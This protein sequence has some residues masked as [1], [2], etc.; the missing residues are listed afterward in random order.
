MKLE[1]VSILVRKELLE[2]RRSPATLA[3]AAIM[4][5][6]ALAVAFCITIVIPAITGDRLSADRDLLGPVERALDHVPAMRDLPREAATQSFF[7]QQ[8]LVLFILV[9][10]S[11]AMSLAAH[12]VVGEK[13]GRSL[14]PLLATPIT[15]LELL[16]GKVVASL[17][18]A[19]AVEALALAVYFVGIWSL[20][21]PGV[22]GVLASARTLLIVVV[23][24][25]LAA[26]V[27]LQLAV[28]VSSRVNDPRGAQQIGVVVILPVIG[29]L[30]AQI[31]GLLWLTTELIL[32]V[33]VLLLAG[34]GGLMAVAVR[35]FARETI[36]TRWK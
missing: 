11:G 32:L 12:S 14:E 33:S 24:G 18:P 23:L 5:A 16:L 2:L 36:L 27:A 25:P 10:V 7:F 13:Q 26:L 28:M 35:L 30:V 31:T 1:R 6:A 15:T 17:L 29:V 22:L 34:W 8:F 19:L 9:P 20:A 4:S 21:A 3:P